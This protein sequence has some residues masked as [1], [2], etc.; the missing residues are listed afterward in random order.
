MQVT[1]VH[2]RADGSSHDV[3]VENG[4][5]LV[6]GLD[7][8]IVHVDSNGVY[9]MQ[10]G[11]RL[12]PV[13]VETDGIHG[14]TLW[15][16]GYAYDYDVYDQRHAQLLDILKSSP[17]AKSRT[18]KLGAPMPGLLKAIH[19]ANGNVVRKGDILFTLEAMKMEN[20]IK[21]PAAGMVSHCDVTPGVPVE[22]GAT[23]CIIEPTA[24]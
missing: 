11:D 5:A 6:D 3:G 7:V 16:N 1:T 20:A 18:V 12:V 9:T 10:W 14:I 2:S 15:I 8:R 24:S 21:A 23:L 13:K 4:V 22:K 19:V 17:A